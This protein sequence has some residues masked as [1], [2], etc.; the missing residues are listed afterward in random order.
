MV[1]TA[2][3]LMAPPINRGKQGGLD[4][5]PTRPKL[6][7][8]CPSVPLSCQHALMEFEA[9]DTDDGNWDNEKDLEDED[10][11]RSGSEVKIDGTVDMEDDVNLEFDEEEDSAAPPKYPNTWEIIARYMANF[12]PNTYTMSKQF[13]EEVWRLCAGIQY[14]E[15]GKNYF[16][17]TLFSQGDYDFVMRGGPW[18]FRR[19]ALLIKDFKEGT[20]PSEAILD[21]VPV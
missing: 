14:S 5:R 15:K 3:L 1:R 8:G 9:R 16:M 7:E 6:I 11:F 19:H 4:E 17:I 20:R 13:T 21:S 18:I 10:G 12:K 2:G